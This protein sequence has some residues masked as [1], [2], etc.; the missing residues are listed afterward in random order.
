MQKVLGTRAF[1]TTF[2]RPLSDFIQF[3]IAQSQKF[4]KAQFLNG[5]NK[6]AEFLSQN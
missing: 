4:R 1:H 2:L 5:A 3:G 6:V